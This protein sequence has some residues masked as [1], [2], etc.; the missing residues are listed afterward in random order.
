MGELMS[1]GYSKALIGH[2]LSDIN[3]MRL[4][5]DYLRGEDICKRKIDNYARPTFVYLV[6]KDVGIVKELALKTGY[7]T[8]LLIPF[9]EDEFKSI[10]P[11]KKISYP[12]LKLGS[13]GNPTTTG[14]SRKSGENLW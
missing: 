2:D 6:Y 1:S 5:Q 8:A 13:F 10:F 14:A 3:P 4:L 7:H 9:D 12:K 11:Q